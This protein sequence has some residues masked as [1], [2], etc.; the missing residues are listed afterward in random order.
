MET[1]SIAQVRSFN[2]FYTSV[3]GV[4]DEGLLSTPY[5]LTEARLLFELAQRPESEV[6]RL[7]EQLNLDAGYL[8]RLLGKFETAGLVERARSQTDARRQVVRLTPEGRAV[9]ETLD[10]RSVAEIRD[11]LDKLPTEQR[12]RLLAA[13]G[14][15]QD[16]LDPQRSPEPY[17]LR[18]LRAGDLGWVTERHA[19][20]YA[21]E[22]GF[23]LT[24][25]ALVGKVAAGYAE[26]ADPAWENAWIAELDREPV[27]SVFCMRAT[28]G[29][30]QLRLLL[31]ERQARGLGIGARLVEECLRFAREA[32]YTEMILWTV[33]GLPASRHLYVKAGFELESELP[34]HRFGQ[35]IVGQWWRLRL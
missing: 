15:I 1:R 21:E 12:H 23:D 4:L 25:E 17:T 6:G 26:Q 14:T 2:R 13:M 10:G 16:V 22:F 9:F 35:D 7:R 34:E 30:A 20:Y 8:S 31:L 28:E 3:I 29:V 24:Y 27:G 33:A 11:L 19:V 18:G 5:T 32:G